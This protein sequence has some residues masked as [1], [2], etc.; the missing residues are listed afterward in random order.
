MAVDEAPMGRN[1]TSRRVAPKG[2]V[3]GESR[4]AVVDSGGERQ[5]GGRDY[6]Q[7]VGKEPQGRGSWT[8]RNSGE[9]S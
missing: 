1:A 6:G 7:L 8:P 2:R 9:S 5:G 3:A 4:N